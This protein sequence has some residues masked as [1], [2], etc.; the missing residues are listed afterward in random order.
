MVKLQNKRLIMIISLCL[1]ILLSL[2]YNITVDIILILILFLSSYILGNIVLKKKDIQNKKIIATAVGLG[3]I[4]VIFYFMLLL[5]I[6]RKSIFAIVLAIPI[7]CG[8]IYIKNLFEEIR[9]DILKSREEYI[10]F[11][12]IGV[13]FMFYIA[14][15]SAPISKYDSLTKHLPITM[16]GAEYGRFNYN[17]IESMVYGESMVLYYAYSIMFASFNSFKAIT[18]FNVFISFFTFGMLAKFSKSL[19]KNTN[20][21][22][23]ALLYFTTPMFFELSTIFYLDMLPVYFLLAAI[24][25]FCNLRKKETWIMLPIISFLF[26]MSLFG[27]LTTSYSILVIGII[28]LILCISYGN[29]NKSLSKVL[30]HLLISFILFIAPIA[31][32][33]TNIYYR[34]GNPLFPFYNNLFKSPYFPEYTLGNPFGSSPLGLTL[35]S[36]YTIVFQTSKNIEM[37]NGGLGLYLLLIFI[38]PIALILIKDK[39]NIIWSLVPFVIFGISS[40][41]TDNLRYNLCTFILILAIIV[42]SISIIYD[43]LL[44]NSKFKLVIQ[45]LIIFILVFY[46]MNYIVKNYNIKSKLKFNPEI[47]T[48]SNKEIMNEVPENKK[49][50]SLND[51]FKG[52]YKGFFNA[53]M[54][55]NFYNVKKIEDRILNMNDYIS[56]FDY[57]IYEKDLKTQSILVDE[58]INSVGSERSL[59]ITYKENETHILYKVR[60]SEPEIIQDEK[61]EEPQVSQTSH[62]LTYKMERTYDKYRITQKVKNL[63]DKDIE[64]RF[65]INWHDQNDEFIGTSISTYTVKVGEVINKSKIIN[66]CKDAEY[67]IVYITTNNDEK[68][69]VDRYTIEGYEPKGNY[70]DDEINMYNKREVLKGK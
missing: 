56:C 34:T 15:G 14:Y 28:V 26:G 18:L 44:E 27:K 45:F 19:Y 38:I 52:E 37:Q 62:P 33:L 36:L 24:L 53:Y 22:I 43:S 30:K 49:V 55:H 57:V 1:G 12:I 17:V 54:W 9:K 20:I 39:R 8:K 35:N 40:I 69:L 25:C 13:F 64:M 47:S 10:L 63:S 65:Q 67:G 4:G 59:L 58:L 23:L 31:V 61:F 2:Y 11:I 5:Q 70:I 16:F 7:I 60:E 42:I 50:L 3:L 51:P 29:K 66:N 32:S 41:A 6:G 21:I 48:Y 46:N 68:V